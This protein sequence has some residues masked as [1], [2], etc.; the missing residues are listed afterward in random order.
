MRDGQNRPHRGADAHPGRGAGHL[1]TILS[2]KTLPVPE[3]NTEVQAHKGFN[4]IATAN[5]R[6][7]GVNELSSALMRRFNTVV[8]PVP[9]TWTKRWRSSTARRQPRPRAGAARRN[10]RAGRDSP[11]RHRLPRAARRRD[12]GRQDEGEIAERHALHRGG[13]LGDDQRPGERRV[14]SATASCTRAIS[15]RG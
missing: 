1:I 8:L 11:R 6:D 4:V 2:E 12:G 14:L 3:L 13:D 5:N 7:K 15:P 10:A 9:A